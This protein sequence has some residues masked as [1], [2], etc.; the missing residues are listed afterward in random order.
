MADFKDPEAKVAKW[1][2]SPQTSL[3]R[4][5]IRLAKAAL[6]KEKVRLGGRRGVISTTRVIT[7]SGSK[8]F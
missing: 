6:A 3:I 5:H 8:F 4:K 2:I 1:T 7:D